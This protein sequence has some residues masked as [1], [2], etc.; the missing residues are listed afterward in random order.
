MRVEQSWGVLVSQTGSEII[1][2]GKKTGILPSLLVTNRI[3][4]LSPETLET[5]SRLGVAIVSMPSRPSTGDYL[6]PE[7]L[8]KSLITLHGYLRI[9]PP[10]FFDVYT[11]RV[12]NG[13]PALITKFP[14]LKGFNKQEDI[15]GQQEKYPICGSVIHRVTPEL[16]SGPVIIVSE[17]ENTA[18][19]VDQ[20]YALLRETSLQTWEYF[21]TKFWKF[22]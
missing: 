7:L 21:I 13:H 5:L 17:T 8:G 19:T 15:A 14:E 18:Q 20:A 11:G 22:E 4:K 9:L 2:I 10:E 16:D 12:Y 3:H 6:M 1:T